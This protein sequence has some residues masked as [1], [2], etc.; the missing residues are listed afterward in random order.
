MGTHYPRGF[1]TFDPRVCLTAKSRFQKSPEKRFRQRAGNGIIQAVSL[2]RKLFVIA[3]IA[4]A[5]FLFAEG[6]AH[7]Q[8]PDRLGARDRI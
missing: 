6:L 2:F 4:A 1:L 5:V 3:A 7:S 8:E